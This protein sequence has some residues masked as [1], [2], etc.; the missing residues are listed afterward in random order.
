V[1]RSAHWIVYAV[2][3]PTPLA[4]EPAVVT[5]LAPDSVDL[6]AARAGTAVVHVRYTP[7]W[8]LARGSGCV[9]RAPGDLVRLRLRAPGPVRLVTR[10][11]PGRIVSRAPRC[12]G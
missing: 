6:N 11:A 2:R 5:R 1:W 9:E 10:F 12:R 7:Y 8:A 4:S 3:A